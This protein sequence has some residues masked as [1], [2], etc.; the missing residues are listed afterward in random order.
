M[1]GGNKQ[2]KDKPN[3]YLITKDMYQKLLKI[4]PEEI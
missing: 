2:L 4:R 1:F 3:H